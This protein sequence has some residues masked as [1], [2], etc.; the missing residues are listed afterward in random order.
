MSMFKR[1]LT[2]VWQN[3][4]KINYALH[5]QCGADVYSK[6]I[7]A[8]QKDNPIEYVDVLWDNELF[9]AIPLNI[10]EDAI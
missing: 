4:H 6:L 8:V 10:W 3:K 2:K 9:D 7:D 1:C 5:Q